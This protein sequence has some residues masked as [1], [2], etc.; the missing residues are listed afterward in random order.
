[1]IHTHDRKQH[2]HTADSG[3]LTYLL[4]RDLGLRTLLVG[5]FRHGL[6]MLDRD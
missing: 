6:A 2:P 5:N 1:M 3:L 4:W